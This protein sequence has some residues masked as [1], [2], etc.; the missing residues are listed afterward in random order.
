[1]EVDENLKKGNKK[2]ESVFLEK[3]GTGKVVSTSVRQ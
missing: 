1:M 2:K 3:K